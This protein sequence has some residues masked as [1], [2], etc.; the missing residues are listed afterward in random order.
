MPIAINTTS[1]ARV[2]LIVVARWHILKL[3]RAESAVVVAFSQLLQSFARCELCGVPVGLALFVLLMQC[4]LCSLLLRV[5]FLSINYTRA[6][7]LIPESAVELQ[8]QVLACAVF[9]DA[10]IVLL[11]ILA[12]H[13]L[14]AALLPNS[15]WCLVSKNHIAKVEAKAISI[16]ILIRVVSKSPLVTLLLLFWREMRL[17]TWSMASVTSS[18]HDVLMKR[19]A[20]FW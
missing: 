5:S 16:L 12:P 4:L 14:H 1:C 17:P 7:V 19:Y 8:L 11:P 20:Y 10:V 15:S 13:S 9:L 6:F 2:A 3:A 18:I